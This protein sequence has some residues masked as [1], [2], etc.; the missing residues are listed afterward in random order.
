[1]KGKKDIRK[2]KK[3]ELQK[4]LI[5]NGYAVFRQKQ[6]DHWLWKKHV[7]TFEK[8]NNIPKQ[9]IDSLTCSFDLRHV[10][11]ANEQK[12]KD[13][14]I[15][16]KMQL[17]DNEFIESVI[18]PSK[19]RLTACISSQVGCSLA[20]KFCATGLLDLKRNLDYTEIY[21]QVYILNNECKKMFG[22]ILTNIVFM[23]MG[24]P[25]LNYKNVLEAISIITSKRGLEMSPKRIT[26]STSGI[27]KMIRK[28]GD[29]DVKFNLAISLHA[30]KNN[31]RTELMP[32]NKSIP[33]EDLK[34]SINYFFNKT[35][36][37]PTYEYILI[38][39]VN[40]SIEDAYNLVK[41]CSE[42]PCKINLIE[43]N[44]VEGLDYTKSNQKTVEDF[45]KVLERNN[46]IVNLRRSRGKDIDAACGQ[47][48]N[49]M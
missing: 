49:K 44:S 6:I 22:K 12:S 37:R 32:I 35:G 20:C 7:D 48:I 11:I 9:I 26:V 14:T 19:D 24:E 39:N 43:Y 42:T 4:F 10:S 29:D 28:L 34:N 17:S 46:L 5:E 3:E 38:A 33:L 27:S 31:K 41:F 36:I 40:D 16:Y 8:M 47:L 1:M 23:G 13:G 21:D 15:K 2:L 45:I 18:I 25:L 30:S